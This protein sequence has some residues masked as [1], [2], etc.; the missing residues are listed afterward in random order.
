MKLPRWL[1]AF[2]TPKAPYHLL[3]ASPKLL[4]TSTCVEALR[5]G[6]EPPLDR[7]HEGIAYLLGR[8]DGLITLATCVFVPSARTTASSFYVE[9]RSMAGCM[10]VAAAHELQVVGQAHTHPGQAYHSDGD[11]EGAKIRY[12]GYVSIVLPDYGAHLPNL[13]GTAAYCWS[14]NLGWLELT[15]EDLIIIQGAKPW[16][17][18]SGTPSGTIGHSFTPRGA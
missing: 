11:V 6:L 1:S 16:T 5:I 7:R 12:P 9:P 18:K 4:L 13:D 10:Q 17:S 3:S 15:R 2:L 8:T 14:A